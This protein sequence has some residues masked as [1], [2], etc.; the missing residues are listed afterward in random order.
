MITEFSTSAPVPDTIRVDPQR[1]DWYKVRM[2]E[3]GVDLPE[4]SQFKRDNLSILELRLLQEDFTVKFTWRGV[5]YV[6]ALKAG[7][8]SDLASVPGILRGLV[9]NDA[10]IALI[11]AYCVHD[12]CFALQLLPFKDA[13]DLFRDIIEHRVHTLWE[14][15]ASAAEGLEGRAQRKAVRAAKR[16][17]R[18]ALR[19]AKLYHFGVSTPIGRKLYRESDPHTH[20]ARPYVTLKS[21][22][23]KWT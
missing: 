22:G 20:W 16:W 8:I 12:P 3:K 9:D 4:F 14:H 10:L 17:R 6:L 18:R 1:Y 5:R 11:A 2:W 15:M 13:N 21:G 19:D 23:Q 7:Y